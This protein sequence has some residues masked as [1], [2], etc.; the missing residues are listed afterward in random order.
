MKARQAKKTLRFVCGGRTHKVSPY[1]YWRLVDFYS[2]T[3]VDH[4][5]AKA[6]RMRRKLPLATQIKLGA[7]GTPVI[8]PTMSYA[9]LEREMKYVSNINH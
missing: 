9:E 3:K 8:Y 4:R 1:W 2:L 5:I 7:L 6:N